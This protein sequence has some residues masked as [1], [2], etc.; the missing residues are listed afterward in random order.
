[1]PREKGVSQLEI[2]RRKQAEIAEQLKAAEA[3]AQEKAKQEET[4]RR[5]VL[6]G[7][8]LAHTRSEPD[9]AW[10]RELFKILGEK[11]TRPADR[12]LFPNLP[13]TPAAA[14]SRKAAA[15]SNTAAASGGGEPAPATAE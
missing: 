8:V 3:R 14:T 5:E 7:I 6:G 11:L 2:L 13:P 10:T 4:R 12:T 1:M 15:R 9:S